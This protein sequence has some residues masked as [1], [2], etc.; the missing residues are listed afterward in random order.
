M[1]ILIW[2]ILVLVIGIWI[3]FAFFYKKKTWFSSEQVKN[4]NK[5]M[6]L[7]KSPS[8]SER[9][10]ILELD[11]LFHYILKQYWYKWTFW[12][13]L[14]QEPICIEDLNEVWRLHKIRNKLAHDFEEFEIIRLKKEV[15]RYN[16]QVENLIKV[17]K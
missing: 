17:L 5:K 7:I 8:Y 9:E 16:N 15:K 1:E 12:D 10:K 13:I 2:I 4:F 6:K 3:Y 11:K 14:K